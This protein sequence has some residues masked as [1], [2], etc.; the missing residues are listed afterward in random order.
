[1][2]IKFDEKVEAVLARKPDYFKLK[3]TCGAVS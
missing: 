3:T 1:L 2:E